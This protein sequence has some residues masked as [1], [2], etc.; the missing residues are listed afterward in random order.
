VQIKPAGQPGTVEVAKEFMYVVVEALGARMA[1]SCAADNVPPPPELP[2]VVTVGV[3]TVFN[4]VIVMV[5]EV[6]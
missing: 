6:A 5:D 4:T 1:A 2:L 3:G